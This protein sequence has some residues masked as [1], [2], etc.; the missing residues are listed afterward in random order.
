MS[1]NYK[2]TE[3]PFLYFMVIII[4]MNTCSD[5]L[6][7]QV[8][9]TDEAVQTINAKLDSVIKTLKNEKREKN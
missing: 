2:H 1:C 4:L 5:E 8:Y 9:K 6:S 3:R 7:R